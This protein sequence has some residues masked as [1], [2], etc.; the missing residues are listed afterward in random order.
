M[1]AA[2][3]G[4]ISSP[5]TDTE[6]NA[7]PYL[8]AVIREGLRM[9]PPATGLLNKQTPKGGDTIHGY[10]VP[11]GTQVGHCMFGAQH[12]KSFWG[13]DADVFRPERWIEA[14]PAKFKEMH[15]TTELMFGS[16]KYQCMGKAIALMELNKAIVEVGDSPSYFRKYPSRTSDASNT[17]MISFCADL[18]S[19]ISILRS[20]LRYL[21]LGF[22]L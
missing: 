5:V 19:L 22:I 1:N 15:A 20:Q 6:A 11:E 21:V 18:T 7:L 3:S 16:G 14:D 12:R 4:S 8:Q 13:S 9:L 17:T 2:T 10:F